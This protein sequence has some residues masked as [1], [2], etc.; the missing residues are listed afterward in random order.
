MSEYQ[1]FCFSK[2]FNNE[3][4]FQQKR[5]R[6]FNKEVEDKRFWEIK[7]SVCNILGTLDKQL[8]NFWKGVTQE[9]WNKLLEIPEAK[10]FKEGFEYISDVKIGEPQIIIADK[11]V[12]IFKNKIK[13]GCTE[14][15]L[16]QIDKIVQ[17]M[18]R[19]QG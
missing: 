17:E 14:V 7:T 11:P 3:N 9:Q 6:A 1:V 15:T 8:S 19:K 13:V 2:E 16:E 4:S 5:F 12:E 10:D 18:K